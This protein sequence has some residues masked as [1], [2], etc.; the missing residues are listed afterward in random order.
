VPGFAVTAVDSVGAGDA[1]VGALAVA[2]AAGMDP[3]GAV[4]A[5]CAAGA[6]AVTRRGAQAA[7]PRP[8][9]VLAVTGLAWPGSPGGGG[10]GGGGPGGDAGACPAPQARP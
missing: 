2:L 4:R 7:L 3:A 10:P 8:A 6:A 5:A 9:D 1:F